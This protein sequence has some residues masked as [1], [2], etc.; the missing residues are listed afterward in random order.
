MVRIFLFI[1]VVLISFSS[2]NNSSGKQKD[3]SET[4]QVKA[5]EKDSME[6]TENNY[7][8]GMTTDQIET[9]KGILAEVK[10]DYKK[11][12][13]ASIYK[14]YCTLCHGR[15]GKLNLNNAKDLSLSE[16]NLD[17]RVAQIY[18]GAGVMTPYKGIISD[19]EIVALAYYIEQFRE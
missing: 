17:E 7:E 11:V 16:A 18:H 15:K 6:S 8:S 13:A 10:N 2:C 12:D 4:A 3:G 9:A 5:D 1:S 19:K 14:T